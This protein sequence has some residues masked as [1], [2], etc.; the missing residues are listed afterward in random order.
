M[1]K[2]LPI[3]LILVLIAMILAAACT[4][5]TETPAAATT[6]TTTSSITETV[7]P[8]PIQ[9]T[10]TIVPVITL[11]TT[12]VA[13]ATTVLLT[14]IRTATVFSSSNVSCNST[15]SDYANITTFWGPTGDASNPSEGIDTML[16]YVDLLPETGTIDL[17]K[18]ELVLSTNRTTPVIYRLGTSDAIGTFTANEPIDNGGKPAISINTG[19]GVNIKFK[20]NPIPANTEGKITLRP[21]DGACTTANWEIGFM[22]P[23]TIQKINPYL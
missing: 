22:T 21:L 10:A 20:V 8:A 4:S 13:V 23:S 12:P 2:S 5:S 19:G 11:T 15:Q 14:S 17:T 3:Y 1:Q 7:T 16:L 18:M 9:T 6:V